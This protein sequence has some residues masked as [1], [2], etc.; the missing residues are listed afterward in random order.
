MTRAGGASALSSRG[1]L[2]EPAETASRRHRNGYWQGGKLMALY[3]GVLH[4]MSG[5]FGGTDPAASARFT[6]REY[7]EIG[8]RHIR[9]VQL[10]SYHDELLRD[11]MGEVVA[12]SVVGPAA[13]RGGVK[14]VVAIRTARMGVVRPNPFSLLLLALAAMVMFWLVAVGLLLLGLFVGL[15]LTLF[16]DTVAFVVWSVAVAAAIIWVLLP[17]YYGVRLFRA[18]SAIKRSSRLEAQAALSP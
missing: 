1:A 5:G 8:G 2:H 7:I 17:F 10:R 16:N 12:L 18:W 14:T 4:K 6:R 13:R 9:N 11:A 3:E 15:V